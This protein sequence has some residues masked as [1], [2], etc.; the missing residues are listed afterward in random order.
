MPLFKEG[1]KCSVHCHSD[2]HDC[3]NFGGLEQRTEIALKGKR[4]RAVKYSNT[5][6]SKTDPVGAQLDVNL[7]STIVVQNNGESQK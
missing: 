7:A 4:K 2:D 3:G 5:T 6:Q 1:N